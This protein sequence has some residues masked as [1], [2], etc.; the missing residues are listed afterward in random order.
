MALLRFPLLLRYN[1]GDEALKCTVNGRNLLLELLKFVWLG[2][3]AWLSRLL[4]P[5]LLLGL[6][7]GSH[8]LELLL[9][10]LLLGFRY[11]LVCFVHAVEPAT[12]GLVIRRKGG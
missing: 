8:L 10:L 2:R 12:Q 7:L 1:L 11:H 9:L 5:H 3:V 6:V 4:L